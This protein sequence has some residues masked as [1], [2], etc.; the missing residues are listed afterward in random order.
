VL[1]GFLVSKPAGVFKAFHAV[2][3]RIWGTLADLDVDGLLGGFEARNFV[4]LVPE[5][6]PWTLTAYDLFIS[7]DFFIFFW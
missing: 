5:N 2:H 4:P 3:L 7:E 6:M 1:V